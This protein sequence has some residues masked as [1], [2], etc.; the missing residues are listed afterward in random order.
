MTSRAHLLQAL[1]SEK[2]KFDREMLV[3]GKELSEA[4]FNTL[5]KQHKAN[6]QDLENNFETEKERQR[7]A[8]EKKVRHALV[9]VYAGIVTIVYVL[10]T[11][12]VGLVTG[13]VALIP[14]LH[15]P[16]Q[17]MTACTCCRDVR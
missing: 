16:V 17:Y 14:K 11:R 8:L 2:E 13:H 4:E 1:D 15:V 12:L 5:M 9:I 3:H 6:V 7:K 10:R